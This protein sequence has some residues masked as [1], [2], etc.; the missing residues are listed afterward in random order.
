MMSRPAPLLALA[1][2][3]LLAPAAAGAPPAKPR[4][5]APE[6]T[7]FET[8][9]VNVV[10]LEVFVTDAK[11]HLVTNLTRDDF[12]VL[13]DG[14]PV[15]ISNFYVADGGNP[16]PAPAAAAA[17][18]AGTPP[19]PAAAA[20]VP[21]EQRLHLAIFV[22]N[23]NLT[24]G[25][26]NRMLDS[27]KRFVQSKVRPDDRV[28][29]AT[30]DGIGSLKVRQE[31]T[32]DPAALTAAITAV[33][34]A[35]ANGMMKNADRL[36]LV[37]QLESAADPNSSIDRER[38][39]A[40]EDARALYSQA[41]LYAQ[42]QYEEIRAT[43][44]HLEQFVDS[45]AGLPG[46]KA[47]LYVSGG[48]SM[49][50]GQAI[51]SAWQNRFG[52]LDRELGLGS[53]EQEGI[54]LDATPLFEHLAARAN[55][56]RV[57]LYALQAP[58][59]NS[60]LSAAS[61]GTLSWSRDQEGTENFNVSESMILL[62][63][64]TGGMA[65]VDTVNPDSLLDRMRRDFDAYYSLGFVPSHHKTGRNSKIEVRV[66]DKSLR[67]RHRENYRD[68]TNQEI[69]SDRTMAAL[70]FGETDNPLGV[71]LEFGE[72]SQKKKDQYQ[73]P[74][75]VKFPLSG[76]VLLPQEHFHEGRVM[77]FLGARDGEGRTSDITRVAVP[78]RIPNEQVLTSLGQTV[79]Y[80]ATLLLRPGAQLVAVGVRDEVGNVGATVTAAYTAGQGPPQPAKL[81]EAPAPAA[82]N[83]KGSP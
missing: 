9:D 47:L 37:R 44:A 49:R 33:A 28:L 73:V 59:G 25:S 55:A 40:R 78:I 51:F 42:Q 66:R 46:R 67:V 72:E 64:P 24:P 63:A 35:A 30:Y 70:T 48:M 61:G 77:I 53:S 29:L 8:V 36:Q 65:A 80:R 81:G 20:P 79:G 83:P 4:Q 17:A 52:N 13:E 3:A 82:A 75:L 26:R 45:L 38:D 68:R 6:P 39:V 74:V 12:T 57:T 50:P 18:A 27:L 69:M 31:P 43:V 15:E 32:S 34:R 7:F 71:S 22:D 16:P 21:E 19:P 10:N 5:P 76:L 1:A 11:G 23:H 41:A 14:K 62:S 60:A 54:S 2:A 56:N 58:D